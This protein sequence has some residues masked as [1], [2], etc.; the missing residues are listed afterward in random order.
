MTTHTTPSVWIAGKEQRSVESYLQRIAPFADSHELS[1]GELERSPSRILH[2]VASRATAWFLV[3]ACERW[4]QELT[5]LAAQCRE[6]NSGFRC[7]VV[8][9][10]EALSDEQRGVWPA[11]TLFLPTNS[12]S[13]TIIDRLRSE[14]HANRIATHRRRQIERLQQRSA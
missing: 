3:T 13:T 8:A 9:D 10:W 6:A 14:T 5:D 2:N 11:D 4:S 7:L 1:E 12:L